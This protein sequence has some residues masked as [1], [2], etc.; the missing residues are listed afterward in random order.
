MITNISG[1]SMHGLQT[2][3]IFG[4]GALFLYIIVP[5]ALLANEVRLAKQSDDT[6]GASAVLSAMIQSAFFIVAWLLLV[7]II[8]YLLVGAGGHSTETN[9]AMGMWRF[10]DIDWL[11]ADMTN[12]HPKIGSE[13]ESQAKIIILVLS[14]AKLLELLMLGVL[15]LLTVKLSMSLPLYKLRR[16]QHYQMS[17]EIDLSSATTYLMVFMTGM[18]MFQFIVQVDNML[19]SSV[20]T[21]AQKFHTTLPSMGEVNI[22]NDLWRLIATGHDSFN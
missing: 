13:A 2:V 12:L 20:F 17:T 10:W 6:S 21:M 5:T 14:A 7:T 1:I 4:I 19:L 18:I 3:M 8:A 22:L 9:P 16:V 11:N 15:L